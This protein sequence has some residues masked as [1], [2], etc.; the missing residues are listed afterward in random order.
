MFSIKPDPKLS[1]SPN[2]ARE[3][4]TEGGVMIRSNRNHAHRFYTVYMIFISL[5]LLVLSLSQSTGANPGKDNH[6]PDLDACQNLTVPPGNKI[7]SHVYA[8]GVQIYRWDGANWIFLF[9]DASLSSDA[10]GIGVVGFHYAG[11]TW[12]SNSGSKVIGTVLD[13]CT[14]NQGSI[15]WLLLKAVFTEGPGIFH[16]VTYIQRVN[17]SGG[18]APA[19]PGSF[20]G[21]VA[22]VPYAAEYFF[23]RSTQD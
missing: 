21:E 2:R 9:P 14:P 4:H 10:G 5:T 8:K 13:R 6:P 17:T 23:Y 11:P 16:R 7:A 15:P 19:E 3:A 22:K 18:K 1:K 12:E 20:P